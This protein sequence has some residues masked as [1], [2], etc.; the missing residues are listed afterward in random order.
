MTGLNNRADICMIN[1]ATGL[2]VAQNTNSHIV[3][4]MMSFNACISKGG[5]QEHP[6]IFNIFKT[7]KQYFPHEYEHRCGFAQ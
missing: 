1:V 3:V 7:A 6:F 2:F 4:Q 5:V